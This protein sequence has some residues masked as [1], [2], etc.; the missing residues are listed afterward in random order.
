MNAILLYTVI[1]KFL[2][3]II[4]LIFSSGPINFLIYDKI[5]LIYLINVDTLLLEG[6]RNLT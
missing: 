2:I 5:E 3:S 4:S 1:E 6:T